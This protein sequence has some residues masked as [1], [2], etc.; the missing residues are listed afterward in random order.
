MWGM[1]MKVKE[2]N[3]TTIAFSYD[4]IERNDPRTGSMFSV[5]CNSCQK[6]T[7]FYGKRKDAVEV[8]NMEVRK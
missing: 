6:Q 1:V 8:W 5:K 3:C 4:I 2:C 7:S